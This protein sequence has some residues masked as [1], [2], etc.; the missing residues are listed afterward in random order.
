[1]GRIVYIGR[2]SKLLGKTAFSILANLKNF[3][4]GRMITRHEFDAFPEPSYHI[5]KKVEPRM[6]PELMYGSIWCE[7]VIRGKRLPGVRELKVGYRPDFRL[8]PKDEEHD[9]LRGYSIEN[10]G[11]KVNILP[12]KYT[13]P[14]LMREYLKRHFARFQSSAK[15]MDSASG[16]F[17]IPFVYQDEKDLYL[18]DSDLFWIANRVAKDDS[19]KPTD[20]FDGQ[21]H[22]NE[23]YKRNCK[24]LVTK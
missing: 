5:V 4:I 24:P 6:D 16:Q 1:M 19:E 12:A 13:V 7:T 10:L 15:Y 23:E 3:G 11:D 2:E 8:I 17:K 9:F 14:P 21:F 18:Y 22:F 20:S